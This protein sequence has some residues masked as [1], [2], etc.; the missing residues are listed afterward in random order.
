MN[1]TPRE[2]YSGNV[3]LKYAQAWSMIHFFYEFEKGKYQPLI[4]KYFELLRAGKT[5]R[6]CY[7]AV[8]KGKDEALQKEWRDFTKGLKA[9]RPE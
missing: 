8:F 7:D 9:P 4:E 1:E 5:P 6:E 3:G 2:F